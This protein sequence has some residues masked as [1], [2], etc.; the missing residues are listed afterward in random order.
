MGV[1]INYRGEDSDS[2]GALL[3]TELARQFGV[4]QVFLDA[5]S[6]PAGADF[7]EELLGRVRSAGVLLAV[8]GPRWLTA[9]DPTG[10]RRIDDPA[11]WIRRE[12]AE[13]FTAGVRVIPV[14][15]EQ[16]EI[17]AE[18]DLPADI[19]ALSRCQ[20]RHLR[21][22]EPIADLARIVTDL[23]GLDPTLTARSRDSA[24]HHDPL[25]Q[26]ADQL[27]QAVGIRWR[28]EEEQRQIQ[29]PI[30]LPV[31]WQP[32]SEMVTDSLVNIY[33]ARAG[34][35]VAPLK[36]AGQLDQIVD[37]H[38]RIPSRRLVVLGRAGSGKTILTLRFVLEL[39]KRR[40]PTDTGP[41]PVIFSLGSWNPNTTSLWTWLTSQLVRDH[42]GLAATGPDGSTLAAA[43][44]DAD[45]ILPV[46]DGFDEIAVG[47]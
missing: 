11:D 7:V 16:V 14:L 25:A 10:R 31:R 46:L 23:A 6:I 3:Y 2:Y 40:T 35:T 36:L 5:E 33:R 47:L 37:V 45:R 41:V 38:Q 28:R 44:V 42:P 27:A 29:D 22:R 8:I 34:V 19:A 18:T 32:A 12:L 21:R 4:E 1:F 43:L 24:P 39:L 30:P 26:A 17:P 20:Y 15:T 13:A 9:A